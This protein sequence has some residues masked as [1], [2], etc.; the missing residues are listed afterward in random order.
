MLGK[1]N[2][3]AQTQNP[4]GTAPIGGLIAK[5]AIPAVISMLVSALYNI[6]DQIFIG[7]GV[8]MLGN[9][10]TNIAF[11]VTIISTAT[12]LLLGIGSASNYN[13][14]MGAGREEKASRIAGTGLVMLVLSGIGIA[15]L[16]ILFLQPLLHL[17]GGTTD[18]MPYAVEYVGITALG[19]PFFI[20][21]T[22]GNHLIRADRSPTYSMACMLTG[23]VINTILDPLFIFGFGWGIQGAA[24][25]TVLGQMVSGLLVIIYF[26]KLRKMNLT[27]EM[28]RPHAAYLKV[29]ASLG[30]A[31]CINQIA[32]AAV[33]IAMNNTL[34]YYGDQSIYGSDIP[35]ACV[36]IISKVNQVFMAICIGISQG[37]Q[38]IWG[39][40]YGA[41]EYGRVKKTY[42]YSVTLCTTVA[43]VFFLCFQFF[44][45]QIVAVFGTGSDL[46]FQFAER[47]LKIFMLL[48]FVNGIQPMSSGFFTSIGKA[49]LG[50]VMS[51]TRQVAFLL[52]LILLF[53]LFLGIDGVMYAGPI[54]DAAAFA[55]A[56]LFARR[57]LEKMEI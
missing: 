10:A 30:L 11:P 34:R 55:L 2:E 45:H 4:L 39:F 40:N 38:P 49:K 8:G 44:P 31:S 54:A 26:M 51:L 25:A 22:G 36:G 21:T 41:K 3:M 9:A 12:A 1:Q 52:P 56:V 19:I 33:Q 23:A 15:V 46:Y 28:L 37:C 7:Q 42:R 17:F 50:I 35:I 20:L 6:V 57:E 27:R 13:L 53:P 43:V 32:M 5:F 16:T 29:I 48:T 14:E 47:Y 18:V 24:W